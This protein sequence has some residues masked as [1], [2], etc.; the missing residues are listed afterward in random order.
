MGAD[1]NED[2]EV[3]S[4][5]IMSCMFARPLIRKLDVLSSDKLNDG[6]MPDILNFNSCKSDE[7]AGILPK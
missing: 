7:K 2:S 4:D 6:S 1:T 5:A 3:D